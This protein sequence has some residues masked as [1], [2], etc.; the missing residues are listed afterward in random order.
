MIYLLLLFYRRSDTSHQR[1]QQRRIHRQ[2]SRQWQF[3]S[4][5]LEPLHFLRSPVSSPRISTALTTEVGVVR[6]RIPLSPRLG[7]E[8][9]EIR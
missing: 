6:M 2:I 3:Y 8:G 5:L 4:C 7:T 9:L 1:W